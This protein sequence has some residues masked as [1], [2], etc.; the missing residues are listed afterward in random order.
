[1]LPRLHSDLKTA[2]RSKQKT[3]L[4]VIRSLLSSITN[5]SK[6]SSPITTDGALLTLLQRTIASSQS[7]IADFEKAGRSD[8]VEKEREQVGILQ[9]YVDEIPV[10]GES[11]VEGVVRG[12]VEAGEAGDGK[13]GFGRVMGRVSK[14]LKGKSEGRAVDM[15]MV[16]GVVERVLG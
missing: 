9:A 5:A 8:L 3:H 1:V 15:E 13:G 4:L 7:S 6:T 16:K 12:C 14:E 11:E 10:V 2:M